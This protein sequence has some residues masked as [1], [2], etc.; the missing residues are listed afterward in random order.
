MGRKRNQPRFG[1]SENDEVSLEKV[2]KVAEEEPL[3]F[4]SVTDMATIHRELETGVKRSR[5]KGPEAR[6]YRR[7][8]RKEIERIRRSGNEVAIPQEH[9]EEPTREEAKR[10]DADIAFMFPNGIDGE[11]S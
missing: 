3:G 6:R 11:N 2:P 10:M 5:I 1:W 4:L 8:V 7:K 9:P